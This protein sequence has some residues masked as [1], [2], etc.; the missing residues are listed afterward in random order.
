MI[1]LNQLR[2]FYEAAKELN[3]SVAAR[4]LNVTQPAITVQIKMFEE[5]CGFKLFR[6]TA[7]RLSLTDAGKILFVRACSLFDKQKK[8]EETIFDLQKSRL[9]Y[10]RIGTTK[11]YARRLMP[12]LLARFHS[13]YS[14][15]MLELNEGSSLRMLKGLMDYTNT[16]AIVAKVVDSR[17]LIFRPLLLEEVILIVSP[18][19]PWAREREL[20]LDQLSSYSIIM[21]EEGSGTNQIVQACAAKGNVDLDV[22]M[23]TSNMEFIKEMVRQG[24]AYS[25]VVRSSVEREIERGELIAVPVE[26]GPLHLEIVLAYLSD[27]ELTTPVAGFLDFLSPLLDTSRLPIGARALLEKLRNLCWLTPASE[28]RSGDS[29]KI[30]ETK[31]G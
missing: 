21:K 3:F 5:F 26:G 31:E 30:G 8:L 9:G 14:G 6:K 24:Q 7:G 10:L 27:Q 25:F 19:H 17:N 11:T 15:I 28:R 2:V 18:R 22:I 20:K 4:K 16:F 12:G 1:N 13:N 23:Q 29:S